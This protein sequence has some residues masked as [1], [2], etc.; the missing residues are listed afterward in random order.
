MRLYITQTGKYVGTQVEAK[1][2]GKDWHQVE[3]P[4]DKAGL[5]EYLNG[6]RWSQQAQAIEDMVAPEITNADPS[7]AMEKKEPKTVDQERAWTAT[8]IEDFI[9]S[10]A[11]VNETSNIMS[12]LA[13]RFAELVKGRP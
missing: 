13:V 4:T 9:L 7:I 8:E 2:D 3:V 6:L 5:I 10:R 1:A 11:S 12:R